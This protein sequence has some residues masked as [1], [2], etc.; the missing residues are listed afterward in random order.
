MAAVFALLALL[1]VRRGPAEAP[2]GR[3]EA[4]ALLRQEGDAIRGA[5]DISASRLR[6][7][8]GQA[9]TQSQSAAIGSVVQLSESL[10]K[11]VDAF[12]AR[13]ETVSRTTEARI[14]GIGT[15]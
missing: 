4:G 8:V 10:M 15:S 13:L 6:Q 9:L 14:E 3:L 12:G 2:L 5:V 11:Q 7:E 1:A